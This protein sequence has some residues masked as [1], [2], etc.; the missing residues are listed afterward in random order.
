MNALTQ[1]GSTTALIVAA[2][3]R[4]ATATTAAE[5]LDARDLADVA[6][7]AAKAAANFAKVK[8]AAEDVIKAAWRLQADAVEIAAEARLRLEG[9]YSEAQENGVVAGRAGGGERSGREHSP[10]P[11]TAAD[12]GLSRKDI[13]E[14]RQLREALEI[15]PLLIQ[16]MR[17]K[18]EEGEE[19]TK[20]AL[21]ESINY[22]LQHPQREK[23]PAN[24]FYQPNPHL[25]AVSQTVG[26]CDRVSALI[27]RHGAGYI[28]T[29]FLDAAHRDRECAIIEKA[30][31]DLSTL[32]EACRHGY[33]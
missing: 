10:P 18:I 11:L 1:A 20:A 9:E 32:I 16:Q 33:A 26:A 15:N 2:R 3:D 27:E 30:H 25:D 13:H 17:D 21:R 28:A 22:V 7:S 19:P 4:L 24:P 29:G 14:A 31:H 5:V 23:R 8:G 12:L 6:Y